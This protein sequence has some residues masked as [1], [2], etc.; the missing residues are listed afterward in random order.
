ME[1]KVAYAASGGLGEREDAGANSAL[2][3]KMARVMGRLE[4]LP[5]KGRNEYFGYD[6]VLDSDVLDAVRKAMAE[7]GLALFVSLESWTRTDHRTVVGLD[8][9]FADGESGQAERVR[10][11]GEALDKQDK[12]IAKATTAAVKYMLLKTFLIST[13]NDEDADASD[14]LAP[15]EE[16]LREKA[17]H[18]I[19]R[20]E[21]RRRFWAWTKQDLALSDDEVH[22]ALEVESVYEFPGTMGEAKER[23][24]AW[25]AGQVAT[26]AEKRSVERDLTDLGFG[27]DEG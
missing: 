1:T 5:K 17:D 18:W 23:I 22:Q 24:L 8:V 2:Y 9:T 26:Q 13:G 11:V 12:G 19:A 15:V 20:P 25:V 10:W 27:E 21:V 3:A 6:Y 16:E 7:E 4:R 14:S